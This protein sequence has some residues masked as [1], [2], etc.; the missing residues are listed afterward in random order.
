MPPLSRREEGGGK[1]RKRGG[2][3]VD[4][5]RCGKYSKLGVGGEGWE[6]LL[7]GGGGVTRSEVASEIVGGSWSVTAAKSMVFMVVL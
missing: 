2:V 6:E 5:I 3:G 4:Q 1:R 7:N